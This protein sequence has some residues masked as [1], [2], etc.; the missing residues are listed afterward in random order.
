MRTTG[1]VAI[2]ALVAVLGMRAATIAADDTP[3]SATTSPAVNA[4]EV[5][6]GAVLA[7]N[8]GNEFDARLASLQRQFDTLF[9]YTSYRLVKEERQ[10]VPW[11]GKVAFDIPGGRYLLVIPREFKNERIS[12][13]VMLIEGSRPVV[14]TALSLRNHATFLVGG[15][16]Q[17]E[18]VLIL[19]IGADTLP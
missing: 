10:Q 19:S 6:I 15:P 2:G 5:R 8:S 18:G 4:V 9:R 3:P 13:K 14:D 12:M 16:Q 17:H 7:S 1:G 11:G